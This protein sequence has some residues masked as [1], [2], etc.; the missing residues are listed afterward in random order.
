MNWDT[1]KLAAANDP[2][3]PEVRRFGMFRDFKRRKVFRV[4]GAYAV[5]AWLILQVVD[6]M[7]GALPVPDWTLA[8]VA[9]VLA[10]GFP[11]AAALSW[12]F[13]VTPDGVKLDM[14]TIDGEPVNRWRLIHF[15]DVLIII[16]LLGVLGYL[17]LRPEPAAPED[18]RIAVLP[19]ENLS[20]DESADY[21]G[22]GIAD[23]IRTRLYGLPQLRI[24][25]GSSSNALA[26]EGLD[27]R[28]IGERLGVQHVLEGSVQRDGNR[29]RVLMQLV[30]V[31]SGFAQW[32]KSYS[33]TFEDVFAMQNNISLVVASQLEIL[34]TP[35]VRQA[36]AKSPTD[37]V[38]AFDFYTQANEYLSRPMNFENVNLATSLYQKAIEVDPQFALGHAGL[39]KAHLRRFELSSDT[40]IIPEAE[41]SCRKALSLD[42]SLSEVHSRLGSLYLATDKPDAAR[43]AFETALDLD[44]R[45][46]DAFVG[47]GR[48]FLREGNFVDAEA[49]LNAAVT[50][51]PGAWQGYEQLGYLKLLQGRFEESAEYYGR[52]L[53]LSPDNAN[54]LNSLGVIN[55][56]LGNFLVAAERFEQSMALNPN[57]ESLS[58]TGTMYYYAG[59]YPQAARFFRRAVEQVPTD[60]RLWGHLADALRFIDGEQEQA[61]SLYRK[62]IDMALAEVKVTGHTDVSL[63]NLA[64]YHA[65][66]GEV[67]SANK[68]IDEAGQS[69]T[70]EGQT[71]YTLALTHAL[72]GN[73]DAAQ[74]AI[75]SAKAMGIAPVV[76]E[77]APEL[78]GIDTDDST[79]T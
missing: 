37:N 63:A 55:F 29:I 70:L 23:D 53:E 72:L 27:A 4:M 31:Q 25:A 67:E 57:R 77:T 30:D 48:L 41:A 74:A 1:D 51:R 40:S 18:L 71:Y 47:I 45:S 44:P 66:L 62:S 34:L 10:I 16:V 7:S 32:S 65:N 73:P 78:K 3:T 19:L 5:T 50:I 9:I 11:V 14:S 15:I 68:F 17:T 21:L 52:A 12:A 69:E 61:R 64:W 75:I 79:D 24:A 39:C 35:D 8:A 28:A 13:Q 42:S 20:D 49:R 36:L 6:V 26:R 33:T 38:A 54:A 46:I 2:D 22:A 59:N 43:D 58:N 56:Y 76:I 60:Y